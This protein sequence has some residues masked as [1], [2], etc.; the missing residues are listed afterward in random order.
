MLLLVVALGIFVLYSVLS[1]FIDRH[2]TAA[3]VSDLQ[4]VYSKAGPQIAATF[5]NSLIQQFPFDGPIDWTLI[6]FKDPMVFL[7]GKVDTNALHKFISSHPDTRFLW[8]G[9]GNEIEEGWPSGKDY[10]T[11]T[12]TNIIFQTEWVVDGY[13]ASIQGTVDFRS[14]IVTIRSSGSDEPVSTTK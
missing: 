11:T 9:A 6:F 5:T 8:S 12:W 4:K 1:I 10:P 2:G 7:Y 3:R 14:R 13:E